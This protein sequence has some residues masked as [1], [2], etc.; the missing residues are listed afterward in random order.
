MAQIINSE[1][2]AAAASC[3]F[4]AQY[5]NSTDWYVIRFAELGTKIPENIKALRNNARRVLDK[6][7]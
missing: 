7:G 2:T 4:A 1:Q 5:L 3:A 6:D